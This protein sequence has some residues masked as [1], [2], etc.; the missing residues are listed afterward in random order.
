MVFLK[1]ELDSFLHEAFMQAEEAYEALEVPIG[2]VIVHAPTR[3]VVARGRNRT[4]EGRDATRHAEMEAFSTLV[5]LLEK[6]AINSGSIDE[7]RLLN[8]YVLFVTVEP[9]I[10]CIAACRLLGLAYIWTAATNER[11]GGCGSIVS[12]HCSL[13]SVPAAT[14]EM[15]PG[16]AWRAKSVLLLRKFYLR[17]NERAPCPK[18]KASRRLKPVDG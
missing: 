10:M 1:E 4:N 2:C 9:C 7:S 15:V 3:K 18:Q 16:R 17:E 5:P 14:V 11:F 13:M 8:D 12:A 6:G